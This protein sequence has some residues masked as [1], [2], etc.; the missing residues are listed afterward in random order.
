MSRRHQDD[1]P[2]YPQSEDEDT[3]RTERG[4][5]SALTNDSVNYSARALN[6]KVSKSDRQ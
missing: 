5:R 2:N 4:T 1:A 3:P 6:A